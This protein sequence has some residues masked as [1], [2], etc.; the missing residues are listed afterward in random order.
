MVPG[1]CTQKRVLSPSI[2]RFDDSC[3]S[4]VQNAFKCSG[5]RTSLPQN[6]AWAVRAFRVMNLRLTR[7][8]MHKLLDYVSMQSC[9]DSSFQ[10]ELMHLSADSLSF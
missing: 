1:L 8:I 9:A 6:H 7:K 10:F 3:F 5:G 2:N 4:W